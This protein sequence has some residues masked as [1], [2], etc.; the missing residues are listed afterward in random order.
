MEFFR[1]ADGY[2]SKLLVDA[3]LA[4]PSPAQARSTW[5]KLARLNGKTVSEGLLQRLVDFAAAHPSGKGLAAEVGALLSE[6]EGGKA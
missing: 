2:E 5:P 1:K 6:Q 4:Q 3:A